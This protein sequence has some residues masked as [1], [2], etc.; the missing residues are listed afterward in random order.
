MSSNKRSYASLSEAWFYY[1]WLK[2]SKYQL[3]LSNNL[4]KE[5]EQNQQKRFERLLLC[6]SN[7]TPWKLDEGDPKAPFSIATTPRCREEC[8]S[9]PWIAPL[10]PWSLPYNAECWARWHQLLFFE[11]LVWFNLGLNPG[12]PDHWWTPYSLGQWPDLVKY[13]YSVWPISIWLRKYILTEIYFQK[14][15]H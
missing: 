2:A 12:L 13:N 11:S 15:K 14:I 8:Y 10:Y 7:E 9:I 5:R 4:K 6:F 3:F 1:I